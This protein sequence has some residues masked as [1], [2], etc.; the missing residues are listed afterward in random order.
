MPHFDTN[1]CATTK[2]SF[3][4]GQNGSNKT[5]Q[6]FLSALGLYALWSVLAWLSNFIGQT[7]VSDEAAIILLTGIFA[8]NMLFFCL[9]KSSARHPLPQA[10]VALAQSTFG[11]AWITLYSFLSS[12]AGELIPIIYI[13]VLLFA[14]LHVGHRSLVQ[15]AMFSAASYSLVIILRAIFEP[16]KTSVW[17]E[18]ARLLVFAGVIAW[19]IF[20]GRHLRDLRLQLMQRNASLQSIIDKMAR[21]AEQDDSGTAL[22]RRYMMESLTREKGRTDRSNNP[23]SVCIFNIDYLN[24]F[25]DQFGSL[26]GDRALKNFSQRIRGELRAMDA[27]NP[28]GFKRSF[29]RFGNAEYIVILPQTGLLGAE[30]CAE[31]ICAAIRNRPF[32]NAC[33]Q[34]VSGGVAEYKR[35]ETIPELLARADEALRNAKASGGN[36]ITNSQPKKPRRADIVQLRNLQS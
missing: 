25:I 21:T 12:G 34:A 4:T 31:R 28:S 24:A 35:G 20:Y 13:T 27:A 36:Q 26:A 16:P 30:R 15:L 5:T 22:N 19:I 1:E 23:F 11:I 7:T 33:K 14:M 9:A 18:V 10:T 8:T 6:Q 3:A 17:P 32:D 29:G 2:P